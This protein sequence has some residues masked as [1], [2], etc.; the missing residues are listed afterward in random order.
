MQT[1]LTTYRVDE[2]PDATDPVLRVIAGGDLH[3]ALRADGEHL[4]RTLA[5]FPPDSVSV[6]IR[7]VYQ[8][9][10][11]GE[12]P[13]RRLSIHLVA[14]AHREDRAA[15][16]S[17]L[18][19]QGPLNRFYDLKPA[20]N[21][22]IP[23]KCF[24]AACDVVR[25]QILLEPTV[26]SEFNAKVSSAY[27]SIR[28]F[29]I[30]EEN[31]HHLLDSILD[32]IHD[33]VLVDVCVE[34]ADVTQELSAHTRYRS[35]L[36][37]V[38]RSW[39]AHEFDDLA[40]DHWTRGGSDWRSSSPTNL[41]LLRCKDPLADEVLRNQQRFHETLVQ[42]HL[43]FHIRVW[44]P[45]PPLARLLASVVAESAFA[46]GSYQLLDCESPDPLLEE[47]KSTQPGVRVVPAPQ[48][49]RDARGNAVYRDLEKLAHVAPVDQLSSVF[50][51]PVAAH[52]SPRCFRK[53]TDPSHEPE[54][55]L[56]I[57]GHEE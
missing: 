18:L 15:S 7:F 56:I 8:P 26:A 44:A 57:F 36:Q 31:N 4:L 20:E 25:H 30:R 48:P 3:A 52:A 14:Q 1:D 24:R 28:S 38:N 19:E 29:E 54:E 37:E 50:R 9:I 47:T 33:P 2:V 23:W 35:R 43:R 12:D 16:L 42:P 21:M 51:L 32:R 41:K 46:D 40:R 5:S 49:P 10:A 53:N 6:A 22:P 27:W 39:D 11:D 55:N 17:L 13:Q 34:P 45:N